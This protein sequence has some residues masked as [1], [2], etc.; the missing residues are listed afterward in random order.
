MEYKL[1]EGNDRFRVTTI[2]TRC[3]ALERLE[4]WAD[5]EEIVGNT[6][7]PWLVGGYFNTIMDDSNKLGGLPVTQ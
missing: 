7:I 3:S 4:L 6:H 5:L 2:Y 1:R